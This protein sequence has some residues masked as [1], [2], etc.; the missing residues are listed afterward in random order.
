MEMRNNYEKYTQYSRTKLMNHM[1]AFALARR[2]RQ[3][4]PQLACVVLEPGVIETKLLRYVLIE[5][6]DHCLQE[7]R[8]FGSSS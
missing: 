8:L 7:W 1:T 4:A 6:A 3:K 2:L 5:N